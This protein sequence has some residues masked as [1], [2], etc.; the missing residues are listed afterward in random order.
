MDID[1]QQESMTG[2]LKLIIP[3]QHRKTGSSSSGT[4]GIQIIPSKW[5]QATIFDLSSSGA[6]IKC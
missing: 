4:I 3:Y 1:Y 5:R 6:I 2:S